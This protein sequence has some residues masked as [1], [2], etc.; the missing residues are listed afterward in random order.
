MT[1]YN[2]KLKQA[3]FPEF[4]SYSEGGLLFLFQARFHFSCKNFQ[5]GKNCWEKGIK[6][7]SIYAKEYESN[8]L[9]LKEKGSKNKFFHRKN[10]MSGHS[11]CSPLIMEAFVKYIEAV[12][13]LFDPK[14]KNYIAAFNALFEALRK[15]LISQSV[16]Y[17]IIA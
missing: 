16:N 17:L 2:T 1:K 7:C 3:L 15:S 14:K 12:M 6:Y 5:A 8:T 9:K 10:K 11:R 4:G 13:H